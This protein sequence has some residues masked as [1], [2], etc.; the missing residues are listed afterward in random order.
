MKRYLAFFFR[1]HYPE[2]G[3]EDFLNDFITV[4]E[5]L[6]T[7]QEKLHEEARIYGRNDEDDEVRVIYGIQIYDSLTREIIIDQDHHT[8]LF[9]NEK[10]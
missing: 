6:A 3:M 9:K 7:I 1:R 8:F 5:A 2:G 10:S 4:E